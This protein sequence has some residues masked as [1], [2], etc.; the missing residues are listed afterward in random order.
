MLIR[1]I[2]VRIDPDVVPRGQRNGK[3]F[4]CPTCGHV[5]HA[6]VNAAFN[7]ALRQYDMVNCYQKEM[8][9][10]GTLISPSALLAEGQATLEPITL[11]R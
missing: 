7:I 11:R 1:H 2:P 9:A 10:R 8:V 6:D 5:D 3:D 4:K